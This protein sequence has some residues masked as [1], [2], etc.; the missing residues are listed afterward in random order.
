MRN[1]DA[2]HMVN[3]KIDELLEEVEVDD[4]NMDSNSSVEVDDNNMDS[5]SS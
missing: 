5:I 3:P 2:L 4:N 1:K